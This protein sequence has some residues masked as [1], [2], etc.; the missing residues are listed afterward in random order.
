MP[1][2]DYALL[3][4]QLAEFF[5]DVADAIG[6]YIHENVGTLPEDKVTALEQQ[7]DQMTTY[8]NQF[9]ELADRIA[10][11]ALAT[12]LEGIQ[13]AITKIKQDLNELANI[14]KAIAIV[15]AVLE[16]AAAV[17]TQSGASLGAAVQTI[18]TI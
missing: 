8:A 1:T 17:L 2:P 10:F 18:G 5:M 14:D 15:A 13:N 11:A 6:D 16:L 3:A 4:T 7:L 12:Y 9:L